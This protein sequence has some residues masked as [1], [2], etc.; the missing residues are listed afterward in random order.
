MYDAEK[1]ELI[2]GWKAQGLVL[3]KKLL[4]AFYAVPREN[5]VYKEDKDEAYADYPLSIYYGQT[6]SQ[7]LTVMLM[8]KLL[9]PQPGNKV[10]E[11]GAGSGYQAAILGKLV[12]PGGKVITIEIIPELAEFARSNLERICVRNVEVINSDGS[13][14]YEKEAPYDRIIVTAGN[15]MIPKS[16]FIQLREQGTIVAPIGE[17]LK[18]LSIVWGKRRGN[19]LRQREIEHF[20]FVPLKG[21]YGFG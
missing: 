11:V 3:D 15:K 17:N 14:G 10:L 6:I 8:T 4:E 16:L 9:N 20:S 7:P 1:K 12:E 13:M 2:R 5:F 18:D 19:I 21:K